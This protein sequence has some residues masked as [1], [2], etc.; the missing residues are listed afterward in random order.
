[1]SNE[2]AG[3]INQ[4]SHLAATRSHAPHGRPEKPEEIIA[5]HHSTG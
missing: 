5:H 1:M 2:Y 3:A 4:P